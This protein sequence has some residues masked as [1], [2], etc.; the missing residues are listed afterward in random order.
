MKIRRLVSRAT[1]LLLMVLL[2]AIPLAVIGCGDDE[3]EEAPVAPV[4]SFT[5]SANVG[6]PPL[7]VQ[8]TDQS[9]GEITMYINHQAWKYDIHHKVDYPDNKCTE[10]GYVEE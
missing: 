1:M 5:A 3:E 9:T 4:A 2:V 7:N 8:F 10:S 6:E